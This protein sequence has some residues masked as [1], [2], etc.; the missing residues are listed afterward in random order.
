MQSVS[1]GTLNGGASVS[2]IVDRQ[3]EAPDAVVISFN[4]NDTETA[5]LAHALHTRLPPRTPAEVILRW[6][7]LTYNVESKSVKALSTRT[8]LSEITG[9][10]RGG[11]MVAIIGSSG[12]GK[13]TLLNA[14]SGRIVGGKLSGQVL[15]HGAKRHPGSYKRLTAY[16]Q[17]DDIMHP[18]LTV[19][20]TL[21]Y[22]AKL[23][24]SN[25][26]YTAEKKRERVSSIIK[27][28]RLSGVK[29]SRIG[30]SKTRGVSGG[31]RKRVSIGAEL[32]TDPDLL[33][34]DEPTSGLDSNSSQLV[35]ELVK[36]VAQERQ[37]GAMMTIHQPSARIF[38]MFDKVILLSQGHV[39][40]F[41]STLTAIDYFADIGY[42]CPVHENPADYFI[43]LMTLDYRTDEL[44]DESRLR[45]A[46]L[47]RSFLQHRAKHGVPIDLA[48]EEKTETGASSFVS[49][50]D[51]DP[52]NSWITEFKTLAHRDWTNLTRNVMFL[53]SQGFQSLVTALIVGFMFFYLKH[54]A[55]SIQNR[56]GV[57]F[58]VVLNSTFP[59]VMPSMQAYLQERD[60]ML[61]E[62]ASAVYRVTTF[63]IS[64]ATTFAPVALLNGV[65]FVA[66][67]YFISHLTF[68]AGKFFI[69]L[70]VYACSN[71]VSIA[72]MLLIGSAVENVDVAFVIGPA[73]LTLQLLFG[74][75]LANPST[76][77]PV[78]RWLRWINPVSY[79]YA[80]LIQ[81]E[82]SGMTFECQ[83]GS[84]CYSTGEQVIETYSMGR[85]SIGEN[86]LFQV[87][88]AGVFFAGGYAMLRWKIKPKYIWI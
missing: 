24:L 79:A 71:V 68:D 35:V 83:P 12:A 2:P 11:E 78:L 49:E 46:G 73:L 36:Q 23:R 22:A 88:L 19:Q 51:V 42:H 4:S 45:V 86:V 20:E 44:L 17:Q 41:G 25:T 28:L 58:V 87:L 54:D 30:D 26:Q 64:K 37:I 9:E 40:Y 21:T 74:G 53:V 39:V 7:K 69:A 85:F 50:I 43:D 82:F 31:E 38:N 80:A 63:Y 70:G 77:T 1:G 60:I 57:L 47:A 5:D 10:V 34:L 61:R 15:F 16:V 27:Q 48:T 6:N 81:N 59:V 29:D 55:T 67:V 56:L 72:F 62:R 13:T 33:F 3:P 65:V 52:R 8:I 14:L 18:L 66:G 32:L 75:L 76:I 84:Q